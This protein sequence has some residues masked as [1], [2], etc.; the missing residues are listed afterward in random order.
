LVDSTIEVIRSQVESGAWKVGERIPKEA[1]L[2][3]MLQVGRNTV[4]EAVRVLSHAQL[5]EVRQGDGTYVR[6]SV[7][8]SE[9][10][11]RVSRSSLRDHLELRMILETEASR[12]AA[13]RRTEED[14]AELRRL[15]DARGDT[16]GPGELEGHIDRD[17]AFHL[18]VVTS[19][20]NAALEELY[21]YFSEAVRF[22]NIAISTDKKLPNPD[23][24]AHVRILDAIERQDPD[25]AAEAAQATLA[26][27]IVALNEYLAQ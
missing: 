22:T 3:D 8:P 24:A 23:L 9:I 7:D 16:S 1:E 11:R 13:V 4:R 19:A 18:A 17:L 25:A 27:T 2:A 14:L 6:S 5:L 26:P 20:H 10:M 12:L 15:L 21:R